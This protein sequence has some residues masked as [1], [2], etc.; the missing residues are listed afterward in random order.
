MG[1]TNPPEASPWQARAASRYVAGWRDS[2]R[3]A[4]LSGALFGVFGVTLVIVAGVFVVLALG[5]GTQTF[6]VMAGCGFAIIV[7]LLALLATYLARAVLIPIRRVARAAGRIGEGDHSARVPQRGAGEVGALAR[8][9]NSMS[10]TLE[11]RERALRITNE[12]FQGV[13]E[14][15]NAAI[16]IKDVAGRY[17]LVNREFERIRCG[18]GRRSPRPQRDR[19]GF[20]RKGRA[21]PGERQV[22]D[23]GQHGDV[24]RAGGALAG[25]RSHV[26]PGE[27]SGP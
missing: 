20:G 16:Y 3:R 21:G 14:N 12:R 23:R 18:N 1:A 19:A 4:S 27:V 7:L 17:L 25:G 11:E 10:G 2:L 9:F 8:A 5:V 15:A 6:T 13:L 22:G 24:V 26:P